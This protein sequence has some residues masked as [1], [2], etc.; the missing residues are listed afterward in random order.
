MYRPCWRRQQ[1]AESFWSLQVDNE[2]REAITA[3]CDISQEGI[4]AASLIR[5]GWRVV[6]RAT[7]DSGLSEAVARFPRA[8]IV[9]SEDF[10]VGRN[11]ELT[12]STVIATRAKGRASGTHRDPSSDFELQELLNELLQGRAERKLGIAPCTARL[13]VIAGV[14][15]GVGTS[16]IALNLAQ[17][18]ASGG[19]STLLL[20]CNLRH[21]ALASY[22]DIVHINREILLTKFGFSLG[23]PTSREALSAF[24]QAAEGYGK[25]F[26]D[27]GQL[28][29]SLLKYSGARFEDAISTWSLQ[30]ARQLILLTRSQPGALKTALDCVKYLEEPPYSIKAMVGIVLDSVKSRRE[31][32]ALIEQLGSDSS[33]ALLSRD[34]RSIDRC[35]RERSTLAI[36]AP[37]SLLRKEISSQLLSSP[38]TG[39]A[40]ER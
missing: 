31:R 36:S 38:I 7:S 4:I 12:R 20:D 35:E 37:N 2:A 17:E 22:L 13:T 27:L 39:K 6:Y 25:V 23:E 33:V 26:V 15:A 5:L 24:S 11:N 30:S 10:N 9:I 29:P 1:A 3:I 16:T 14:Q 21:P 34:L 18:S 8:Q 19:V 40:R 28:S 32:G